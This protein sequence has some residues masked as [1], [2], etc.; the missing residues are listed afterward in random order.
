MKTI[1]YRFSITIL[2]IALGTGLV[3]FLTMI[4]KQS[5]GPIEDAITSVGSGVSS[6]ESELILNSREHTRSKS[7]LWFNSYRNNAKLLSTNDKIILGVYDDKVSES[8]QSV[9]DLE[10]SLRTTFPIIHLY[11]A[12]G[13]KPEE[14]FPISQVK[15]ISDIGSIPVITWEPW[16]SDFNND[17]FPNINPDYAKRD[18]N[19]LKSITK[20]YYDNYIDEWAKDL[21]DFGNLTFVRLGHEM[22]DPYRYPWGPQN[23][24][25]EDF[26]SAWKYVVNRF[27]INGATNVIWV[28]SPHPAYENFDA[29]YPGDNY[30]DWIGTGTLN[31]GTVATWSQWWS[32]DEIFGRY[33]PQLSKYKKPI[34]ITEFGSLSVGGNRAKWYED[35]LSSMPIKYPAIKSVVFFHCLNDNTT[36]YKSLNWYVKDDSLTIKAIIKSTR[37]FHI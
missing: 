31:Y 11:S 30:V 16:L 23:N 34:I 10:S 6:I 33:Y 36:T 2:A 25:P 15:A 32:F 35:A 29:Y 28:W 18:K 1:V 26:V 21:K 9:V 8:Y 5:S 20:G 13:S 4:G 19:G 14:T 17:D 22:N 3:I 27:K 24:K 12:W 37:N 7:L